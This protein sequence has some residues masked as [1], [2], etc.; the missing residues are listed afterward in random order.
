M[1]IMTTAYRVHARLWQYFWW[2]S[3]VVCFPEELDDFTELSCGKR[4]PAPAMQLHPVL[5]CLYPM[6]LLSESGRMDS[7]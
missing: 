5:P 1:L 6:S 4:G 7:S 2:F 3:D